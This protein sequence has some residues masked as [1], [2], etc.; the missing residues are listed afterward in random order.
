[1]KI[2][3]AIIF[4]IGLAFAAD[5]YF[6]PGGGCTAAAVRE[7]DAAQKNIAFEA[8]NFT[9]PE[10]LR[11]LDR[12]LARG[13][14]IRAIYDR[15][16]R[17]DR[18]TLADELNV[19]RVYGA[20]KIMHNKVLVIDART[21]LTGSFNWTVNAERHNAENLL[22]IRDPALAAKYLENFE[23]LLKGGSK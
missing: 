3:A 19:P 22:V 7:I 12:A 14:K 15:S 18:K 5:V 11:A 10:I 17:D 8:Y 13:V 6:S 21:V 23:L 4:S 9:N 20:E 1:M 16:Q 2:L